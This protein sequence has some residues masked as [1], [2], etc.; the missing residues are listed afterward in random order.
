M[1][2]RTL[3]DKIKRPAADRAA[4][5]LAILLKIGGANAYRD[6]VNALWERQPVFSEFD[7]KLCSP[8][9]VSPDPAERPLV[10]RVFSAYRKAKLAQAEC[11]PVFLPYGGWKNVVD[12][13]YSDLIQGFENNDIDRFHFF[14]A[15][16][17]AWQQPTGIEESSTFHELEASARKR[18][19]FEQRVMAQLIQWWQTF[20]G[21]GRSLSDLTIPR[22][23][24]QGGALVNGHL[25]S[26]SSVFSDFYGRLLAGFVS[27]EQ[28]VI[29]ELGGGFGR[30]CYF[31]SRNL[32]DATYVAFDLP[33]CLC[34]ASYYLMLAF[35][36]KRFLLYGEGSLNEDSLSEYDF[37]FLPSFE[38]ANLE[39][40]SVD[41]FINE[42]SL[43][44]MAPGAC[45]F[46]CRRFAD[47]RRPSGTGITRCAATSLT[48]ERPR[49]SIE[50]T[51]SPAIDSVK[52][53]G[54]A[55]SP[56]LSVT[57]GT[58]SRTICIGI[59]S[60]GSTARPHEITGSF[61]RTPE[62][63]PGT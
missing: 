48:T 49:W 29:A 56:A 45:S 13:A 54:A 5:L 57:T 12:S 46:L 35:P 53:C 18:K 4:D 44:I 6:T 40:S 30:L 61:T 23:G 36:D 9:H 24:N 43:G 15:N 39:E 27:R 37:L 7:I 11:D 17:G 41:L 1:S 58:R 14:L 26:P 62:C 20:E 2:L 59:T 25:I 50:S 63:P 51:P 3:F 16:F 60:A 10:E 47:P 8:S 31:L 28:P 32:S 21:N 19:H 42:N 55:T 52:S 33:E 38:I 22:F 34:C